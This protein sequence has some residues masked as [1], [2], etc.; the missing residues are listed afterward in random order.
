MTADKVSELRR[1][2][3]AD[4]KLSEIFV[5]FCTHFAD[6]EAFWDLGRDTT[7]TRFTEFLGMT[8]QHQFDIQVAVVEIRFQREL[9]DIKMVHGFYKVNGMNG[10]LFYFTDLDAGMCCLIE[11]SGRVHFAR[12]H[13]MPKGNRASKTWAAAR[14]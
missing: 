4:K 6:V 14:Q 11:E 2:L 10:Q 5:Y 1:R 8:A 13:S 12:V 7:E 3:A 9:P